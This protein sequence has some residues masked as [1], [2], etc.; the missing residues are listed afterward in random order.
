M[1]SKTGVEVEVENDVK[2]KALLK[3]DEQESEEEQVSFNVKKELHI[4]IFEEGINIITP[5]FR[6]FVSLFIA[7]SFIYSLLFFISFV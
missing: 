5:H 1:T 3:N 7:I 4:D 2:V 6:L